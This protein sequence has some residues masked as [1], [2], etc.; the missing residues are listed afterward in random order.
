MFKKSALIALLAVIFVTDASAKTPKS[1]NLVLAQIIPPRI[2][3]PLSDDADFE[4]YSFETSS[5]IYDPLEKYNR[6]IFV[7]NDFLDRYLLEYVAKTYRNDVPR[8]ARTAIRNFL[9]NISAPI[10]AF[11]SFLQGKSD[12]GLA[13]FSTFLINSTI[14]VGGL[15]NVA[16]EKGVRY[17][18]EDFGQT[19]GHY[20]VSSGPYLM[21]PF[22]GPSSVRDFSGFAADQII[23]PASYNA[24]K[25][26][27]HTYLVGKSELVALTTLRAVDLRESLIDVVDDARQESFDFYATIRSAYTQKRSSDIKN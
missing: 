9:N 26:G 11:N 17:K 8:P 16:E 20:G 14:G 13:T 4:N 7:L 22:F 5:E 18:A 6:K 21:V 15:F 2:S 24:L 27:G 19:L 23:N 1:K 10:S 3:S 12:N 25:I